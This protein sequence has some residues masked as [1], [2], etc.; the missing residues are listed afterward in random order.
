MQPLGKYVFDRDELL[1]AKLNVWVLE[2]EVEVYVVEVRLSTL[3]STVGMTILGIL[4]TPS[5]L[6][7]LPHPFAMFSIL[8]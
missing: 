1:T 6:S 2:Y 7:D 4:S 3:D 8:T 5:I